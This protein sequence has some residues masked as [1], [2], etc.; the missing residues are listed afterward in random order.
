M[1]IVSPDSPQTVS[2]P[3]SLNP[4]PQTLNPSIERKILVDSGPLFRRTRLR[5]SVV[6]ACSMKGL[7]I[8]GLGFCEAPTQVGFQFESNAVHFRE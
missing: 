2:F 8:E 6:V 5:K 1:V 7:G 4:K 3:Q